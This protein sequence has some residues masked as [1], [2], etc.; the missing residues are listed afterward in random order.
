VTST[1]LTEHVLLRL[2]DPEDESTV[3]VSNVRNYNSRDKDNIPED[4]NLQK[5]FILDFRSN[6]SNDVPDQ[7]LAARNARCVISNLISLCSSS[8]LVVCLPWPASGKLRDSF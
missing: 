3:T 2:L 1:N 6:L 5:Q 7:L 4:L 8:F